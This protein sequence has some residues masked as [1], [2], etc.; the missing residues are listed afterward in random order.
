MSSEPCCP[1]PVENYF[2]GM[3]CRCC[4]ARLQAAADFIV[5]CNRSHFGLPPCPH[6]H[7][8]SCGPHSH[9]GRGGWNARRHC[10]IC[11]VPCDD[12]GACPEHGMRQG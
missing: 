9:D 3:F 8:N 7:R 1:D 2:R 11:S 5:G 10:E 4:G 6:C 12:G